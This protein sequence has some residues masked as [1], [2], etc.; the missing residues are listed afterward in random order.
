[1]SVEARDERHD[2]PVKLIRVGRMKRSVDS[3]MKECDYRMRKR[4]KKS[5]NHTFYSRE[6]DFMKLPV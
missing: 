5:K 2:M 1:M 4:S 6:G 3:I